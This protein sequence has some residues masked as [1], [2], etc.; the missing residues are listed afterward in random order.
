MTE[1]RLTV[2][3]SRQS[4]RLKSPFVTSQETV[5][6]I[7]TI[8]VRVMQEGYVGRGEALGVDYLGET[9]DTM[10]AQ[11]AH[12]G[13]DLPGAFDNEALQEALPAGGA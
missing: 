6:H 11:L 5:T 2:E 9:P 8:H 1:Q 7:D 10:S 12:L 3:H 4:W 13:K